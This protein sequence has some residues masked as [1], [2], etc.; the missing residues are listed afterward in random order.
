MLSLGQSE[1]GS[2]PCDSIFG[3]NAMHRD[4]RVG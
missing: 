3:S 1:D 2:R 4:F